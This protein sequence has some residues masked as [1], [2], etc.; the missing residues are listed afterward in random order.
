MLA[1]R[2][3]TPHQQTVVEFFPRLALL[4]RVPAAFDPALVLALNKGAPAGAGRQ[5]GTRR[6]RT[7]SDNE[8]KRCSCAR[9]DGYRAERLP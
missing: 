2:L 9:Y 4:I 8:G 6:C 5:S 3:K 7:T 1:I